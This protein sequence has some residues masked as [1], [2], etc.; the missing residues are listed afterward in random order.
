MFIGLLQNVNL[1]FLNLFLNELIFESVF[2][3]RRKQLY[4]LYINDFV[5]QISNSRFSPLI[6]FG[7]RCRQG[8]TLL[9]G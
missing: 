3:D 6:S 8:R 7:A 9:S 4:L 5:Q 2:E 1:L